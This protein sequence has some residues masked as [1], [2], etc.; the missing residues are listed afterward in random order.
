MYVHDIEPNPKDKLY[1]KSK[2]GGTTWL[3]HP[4]TNEDRMT[5][6]ISK[7][8]L[9][10]DAFGEF[11]L[12]F[13]NDK[14]FKLKYPWEGDF[15]IGAATEKVLNKLFQLGGKDKVRDRGAR[16]HAAML[17]FIVNSRIF[18]VIDKDT[19]EHD[20]IPKN[21]GQGSKSVNKKKASLIL[22]NWQEINKNTD[23]ENIR[24]NGTNQELV[25][26]FFEYVVWIP[27]G[28]PPPPQESVV[29]AVAKLHR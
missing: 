8:I 25:C 21:Q 29:G 3:L 22:K 6:A 1:I 18:R 2:D 11:L 15:T 23:L 10:D 27:K 24:D 20:P 9:P 13:S 7:N 28:N 14:N 12:K 26:S 5:G 4:S 16:K 19:L 17:L